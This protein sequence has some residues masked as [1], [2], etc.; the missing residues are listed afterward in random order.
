M[1]QEGIFTTSEKDLIQ[2]REWLLQNGFECDEISKNPQMKYDPEI[3]DFER[4]IAG[5]IGKHVTP[6]TGYQKVKKAIGVSDYIEVY[7]E[8]RDDRK[9]RLLLL[10]IKGTWWQ[11]EG[12]KGAIHRIKERY[13][14]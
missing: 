8:M 7:L 10:Y 1:L 3:G 13:G 11:F 6:V 14:I 4:A 2:I 5:F 12:A 9:R